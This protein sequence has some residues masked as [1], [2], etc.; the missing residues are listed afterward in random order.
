VAPSSRRD[1]DGPE[2]GGKAALKLVLELSLTG[3]DP[4]TGSIGAAGEGP[5]VRFHGWIGL[6]SA[7]NSLRAGAH[8]RAALS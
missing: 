7:I 1:H 5:P 3:G 4:I 6:M 8:R 2:P